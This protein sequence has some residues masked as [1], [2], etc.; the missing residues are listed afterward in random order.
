MVRRPMRPFLRAHFVCSIIILLGVDIVL[1][2]RCMVALL[3]P[4][5]SSSERIRWGLVAHTVAMFSFVTIYTVTTLDTQSISYVDNRQF[6]GADG[7]SAGSLGYQFFIYS[8]AITV[9]PSTMFALNQW[10]ADG[11]LV[12]YVFDPTVQVSYVVSLLQL[13]RC[14]VIYSMNFWVVAFPCLMYL[15]SVGTCSS[16]PQVD[17]ENLL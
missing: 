11:L 15:A 4:V 9:V 2:F 6:P 10:L 3:I 1:F 7:W 14:Y 8:K 16:P 13:Y 17:F 12:S 5:G